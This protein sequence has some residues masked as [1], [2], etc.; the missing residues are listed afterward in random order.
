M[1][2]A[3]SQA[4][5]LGL[6]ARK[7]NVEFQGQQVNQARTALANRVNGLY[8]EYNNLNAPVPPS[9]NDYV[10]TSYKVDSTPE[11]YEIQ[12]F[13]KITEGE[14]E[15]YYNLRL[16]YEENVA[17]IYP[18][19]SNN[20]RITA[21][22]GD[23]SY[24]ELTFE[25][26]SQVYHYDENDIENSTITKITGDYEKYPGLEE[27]MKQ[28]G[29][30]EGTYY[31]YKVNGVCYYTSEKDLDNT[32]FEQ[33]EDGK[34][35]YAG[36][37]T[38]EYQGSKKQTKIIDAVGALT[39]DSTGRIQDVRI[40]QCDD[41]PDLVNNEYSISVSQEDDQ[42]AYNDAMNEYNYQQQVYEKEVQRINNETEK[43]QTEDRSL[44]LKLRQLDTEQKAL[45]TEMEALQTTL[46]DTIEKVFKTYDS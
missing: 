40:I 2:L 36:A 25:I 23:T 1:G 38:F 13:S 17:V 8:D 9:V 4:R 31:M 42:K 32:V 11:G 21:K 20:T 27:I 22:K 3:A 37:Y 35:I 41:D 39:Q 28:A 30:T 34:E 14:Y 10:K 24:S 46:K 29:V 12:D 33:G 7:S 19:T 6:T 26:G 18:Y 16:Q 5:F 15:G 44:E 45:S 43:I